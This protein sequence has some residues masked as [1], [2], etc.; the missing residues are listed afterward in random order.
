VSGDAPTLS[1]TALA[2]RRAFDAGFAQAP[3]SRPPAEEDL[4]AIRV[5]GDAY[6]LPLGDIAGLFKD[7][8]VI[9]IPSPLPE[10]LG[11]TS[12]RG[13]I[14]P[15]Y[16]LSALLGYPPG[17]SGRWLV[18][19]RAPAPVGLTFD[20]FEGQV[21]VPRRTI[22]PAGEEGARRHVGQAVRA[23]T[24][25]RQLVDVAS[26]IEAVKSGARPR[27]LPKER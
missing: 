5:A 24:I 17:G 2:L 20:A 9:P 22:R 12:L 21:R 13:A 19:A 7:R 25:L 4:L 14:V 15:V 11:V 8:R 10:L 3:P 27:E 6:A 16:D 26:V 23:G 1:E 18:L